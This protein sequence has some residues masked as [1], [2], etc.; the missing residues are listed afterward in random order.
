MKK[1]L[2]YYWPLLHMAVGLFQIIFLQSASKFL[3]LL[4]LCIS[5]L[6]NK[7]KILWKFQL[8]RSKFS[9]NIANKVWYFFK[10]L[11]VWPWNLIPNSKKVYLWITFILHQYLHIVKGCVQENNYWRPAPPYM[12]K[13]DFNYH[14]TLPPDFL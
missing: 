1:I 11:W 12:L 7:M 14:I 8:N 9:E 5:F 3:I 6:D 13:Q 2:F 4:K 10:L